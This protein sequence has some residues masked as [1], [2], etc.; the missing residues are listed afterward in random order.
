MSINKF[1]IIDGNSLI[2]RAFHAIP[3]LSTSDGIITNAVYGFTNM[4]FKVLQKIE[5]DYIAVAFDK[6]KITF[7][8]ASYADYKAQRKATP[9]EL[10]TQFPLLKEVLRHMRIQTLE[11]ENYEADDIIGTLTNLA[12]SQG[13]E[14]VVLTG[15]RD[16]LQLVSPRVRVLLTKKGITEMEEYDEGR[17][18]DRYGV[19]PTQIIDIKG[20]M[21]DTSDNI[22]GVPG[23]GEKTALKLIQEHGTLEDVIA[24][25]EKLP[26]RWRNKLLEH[27]DQALLSKQLA[28]IDRQVPLNIA[29]QQFKW[30]GPD[31]PS[32][33]D[34]FSRLEFKTLVHSIIDKAGGNNKTGALPGQAAGSQNE[35]DTH[36]VEYQKMSTEE[37]L[38]QIRY[39]AGASGVAALELTGTREAGINYAAL[40]N[41]TG[42][43]IYLLSVREQTGALDTIADICAD[44]QVKKICADGK[45]ALWLLHRH[46]RTLRGLGFD[47]RLAAYL[48]NPSQ[49]Q[50]TL[51]DLAL[52]YLQ[53]VLPAEG[54]AAAAARVDVLGRLEQMLHQK[55]VDTGMDRLYYDVE[56]PLVSVLAD[57]EMEGVAVDPQILCSMAEETG[58]QID[59]L[60]LEIYRLAG[61]EFNINSPKQLGDILFNKMGLPVVKKT[62]TGFSTDASVLEELASSHVIVDKILAYRQLAKLKSTYIDGLFGLINPTTGRIHTTFHQDVTATGRLSSSNPNLQ[63]IPIR[64]QEG[65]RIRRVFIPHQPGNLI[66]TADYS[67]IEL[68]ILAHMSGDLNLIS[69]F[70]QGQDIHTRTAAEVF[71]V[72]MEQVTPEMRSRAKAVNFG[73]VYGISD[74]GLSRDIKVSRA[75]AGKYIRSYFERYSGVKEFID[76]KIAEARDKGYATT[77]LNRRRYL[78]DISSR[79]RVTRAFGERTAINTPIQGSAA[80]IIKLAMV[81]IHNELKKRQMATKMILQ[82]HDELIFDVP[83]EELD[84]VKN[85]VT[86][87][88]EN[89]L[90]LDVPLVVDLKLGPNWYDVRKV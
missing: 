19:S 40:S 52:Q 23:I 9:P 27:Q 64:L 6:G 33:L 70:K 12:E 46:N 72:P 77:L 59:S 2:H 78:P 71:N 14:S 18:W 44:P 81:R 48:L 67:Q 57:M 84:T 83:P 30:Q 31:Y 65:R 28:T 1:L 60:V 45:E 24:G 54:E 32:L 73:I 79:N 61:E 86:E 90:Q 49:S 42:G 62:K 63:N 10:R 35:L 22:P 51:A 39:A 41:D 3:Q 47:T 82:V 13:I 56:L 8:H 58:Q 87:Y 68:R 17:V 11:L 50:N 37:E 29:V 15:D 53:L 7:R 75:E 66:L 26:T 55:L 88:M 4:L 43:T 25:M 69:A 76:R 5:P 80:D 21:G 20:L 36:N 85:M 38:E 74:F 34:I 16:A 89:A